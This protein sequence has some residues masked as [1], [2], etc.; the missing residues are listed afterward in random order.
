MNQNKTIQK[1]QEFAVSEISRAEFEVLLKSSNSNNKIRVKWTTLEGNE[2]YYWMYWDSAEYV[3]GDAGGSATKKREGMVN[4]QGDYIDGDWRTL[5]LPKVSV[6]R[7]KNKL[8]K[9]V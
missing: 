8:Y 6:C 3:G 4:L 9:I 2:R 5:W 1:I 7:F